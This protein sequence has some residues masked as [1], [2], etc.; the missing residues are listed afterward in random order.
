MQASSLVFAVGLSSIVFACQARRSGPD[1][2][3]LERESAMLLDDHAELDD[4]ESDLEVGLE[5]P[6]AGSG[7]SAEPGLAADSVDAL[8]EAARKNVG[9]VFEPAGCVTSS[10]EGNVVT[11]VFANCTGPHGLA[12]F[13]GTVVST[14]SKLDDGARV[15]HVAKAFAINGGSIDHSVTIDYT[16]RDGLLRRARKGTSSGTTAEG[17]AILHTADYVS[18]YDPATRCIEREGSSQTTVGARA[19]TRSIAGYQRCG[20]GALGC[21]K[22]GTITLRTPRS[23]LLLRFPG[24]AAVDVTVNGV[25]KRVA[26]ACDE[27]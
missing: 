14:W 24:G 7:P 22:S 13:D 1:T 5:D 11:H 25:T 12:S 3:G 18:V 20:L 21:P 8:A 16:R 9:L 6:L 10:R 15:Q 2:Q 23:N 26:L 27:R 17:R 19:F 4:L